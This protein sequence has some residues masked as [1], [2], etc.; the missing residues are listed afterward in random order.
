MSAESSESSEKLDQKISNSNPKQIKQAH[1][2]PFEN[3]ELS[4]DD[5]YDYIEVKS[6]DSQQKSKSNGININYQNT[7]MPHD[8]NAI[9]F[10][11]NEYLL[12]QNFKMTSVTFSEENESQDLEDW[13]VVGLN[14]SKPPSICQL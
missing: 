13:D 11:V 10:L 9:N 2:N 8:K 12:E 6:Y 4:N 14:R 1:T 3:D 5:D 7:L